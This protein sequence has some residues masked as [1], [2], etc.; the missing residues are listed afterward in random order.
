MTQYMTLR[1]ATGTI[2]AQPVYRTLPYDVGYRLAS[3]ADGEGCFSITEAGGRGKGYSCHFLVNLRRDD[4]DFL[5]YFHEQTGL[6]TIS[7]AESYGWGNPKIKWSVHK[8][9][10]CL[11]LTEMF[12]EFP[13]ISKKGRDY[14]IW[15]D[16]VIRWGMMG[17]GD[18]WEE[19]AQ[20]KQELH[21]VKEYM[22]ENKE[23][24][25]EQGRGF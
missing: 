6:G 5:R 18:S 23:A 19:I 24:P 11:L 22:S 17:R 10:E 9:R 4:E 20:A 3:L 21:R 1:D 7:N 13:L 8:K 2:S 15:R 12:D 16:A 14:A 25:T